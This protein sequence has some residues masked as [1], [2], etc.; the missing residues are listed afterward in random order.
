MVS[1]EFELRIEGE[2]HLIPVTE[3][4]GAP[5]YA[6][7]QQE[8]VKELVALRLRQ[9]EPL[10]FDADA[11][12]VEGIGDRTPRVR[13]RHGG[14]ERELVADAVV[15]A[16]GFHGVGRAS[17]PGGR[18]HSRDF[19]VAWLGLLVDVPPSDGNVVYSFSRAGL[20][21]HSMRGPTLTRLYLQ[22]DPADSLDA[23][24][25]ERIWS[26]LHARLATP[27]WQLAEGP[28]LERTIA[29]IRAYATETMRAGRLFLAGDAAHIVPPTGAK[30]LNLAVRDVAVLAPALVALLRGDDR[31]ADAYTRTC[32]DHVWRA[33]SFSCRMARLLHASGEPFEDSL[34]A[35][36]LRGLATRESGR[37]LL[38]ED[39]T[40]VHA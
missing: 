31:L 15:G 2:R 40:G 38:A 30:G 33:M 25:D 6:W 19:P 8:V 7:G 39:Y 11:L 20:G 13:Y 22:V 9:G 32:L 4:A 34:R 18:A 35:A 36:E 3:L 16:D 14:V 1:H 26:Q 24:P 17:V 23:W 10:L 29:P 5:M 21:M 12:A 27:G 37:R 28:I